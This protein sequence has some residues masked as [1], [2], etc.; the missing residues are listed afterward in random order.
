MKVTI[1]HAPNS[2]SLPKVVM[3]VK[4]V[5]PKSYQLY[6]SDDFFNSL[7][8]FASLDNGTSMNAFLKTKDK[9]ARTSFIHY[10]KKSGLANLKEKG[11]FDAD[12]AKALLTSFFKTTKINASEQTASAHASCRY[13]TD[14]EEHSLVRLCTVLGVMGYGLTC[15]D[16]HNFADNIVNK[17]VDPRE[18]VPISKHVTDGVLSRH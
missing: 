16:M 5:N 10:Y 11:Q 9:I 17:N 13:L 1:K 6:E 18:C 3:R 8:E 2:A 4:K 15:K 14:N 7:I 12:V